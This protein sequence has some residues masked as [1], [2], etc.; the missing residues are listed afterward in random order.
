MKRQ[1]HLRNNN[2]LTE[3]LNY[4]KG[5]L[6]SVV[7]KLSNNNFVANANVEVVEAERKKQADAEARIKVIEEQIAGLKK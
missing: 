2:K 5:F 4:T 7:R 3:E 6:Q 1:Y